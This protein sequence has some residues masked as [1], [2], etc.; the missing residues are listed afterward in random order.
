MSGYYKGY[1]ITRYVDGARTFFYVSA[2]MKISQNC[3][4]FN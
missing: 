3:A 2:T 1:G 4:L